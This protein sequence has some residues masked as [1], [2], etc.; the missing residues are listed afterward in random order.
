MNIDLST[1]L[2]SSA[3]EFNLRYFEGFFLSENIFQYIKVLFRRLP[4][5]FGN[6]V[7]F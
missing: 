1:D 3:I 2:P 6:V 7:H 5:S 4:I